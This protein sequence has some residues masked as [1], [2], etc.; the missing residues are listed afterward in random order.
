M[1]NSTLPPRRTS[2]SPPGPP[3]QSDSLGTRSFDAA[4]GAL[5]G[6]GFS[7]AI[8]LAPI[9][10][11]SISLERKHPPQIIQLRVT[12]IQRR[13]PPV[14]LNEPQDRRVVRHVVIHHSLLREP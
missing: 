1:V 6:Y 13:Q 12:R 9:G 3:L 10:C 8:D 7:R 2:S 5:K 11:F 4:R 14:P